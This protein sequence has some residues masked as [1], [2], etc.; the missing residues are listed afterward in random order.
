MDGTWNPISNHSSIELNDNAKTNENHES[1]IFMNNLWWVFCKT[2]RK[3]YDRVV[4]AIL[5]RAKHIFKDGIKITSDG[6][7][8]NDWDGG[9]ELYEEVFGEEGENLLEQ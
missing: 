3:Y 9:K 6:D 4:A 8:D 2:A 1:F 7:W 5:I